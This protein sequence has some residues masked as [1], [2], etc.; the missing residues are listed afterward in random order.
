LLHDG[1]AL[2]A[3]AL[4]VAAAAV[5]GAGVGSADAVAFWARTIAAPEGALGSIAVSET[6]ITGF[7]TM[8][9]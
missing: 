9:V 7:W 4:P 3:V 6:W 5:L 8:R 1:I 2:A